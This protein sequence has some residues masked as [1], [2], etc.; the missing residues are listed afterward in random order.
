MVWTRHVRLFIPQ[1]QVVEVRIR[2]TTSGIWGFTDLAVQQVEFQPT[3]TLVTDFA[4]FNPGPLQAVQLF[5]KDTDTLSYLQTQINGT[6]VAVTLAQN[7]GNTS[8][9]L[10]GVEVR[11]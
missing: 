9:V 10:T 1:A 6:R 5:G 4:G 8:P 11:E 2:M 7:T 3:A